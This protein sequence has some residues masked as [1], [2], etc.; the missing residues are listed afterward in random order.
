MDCMVMDPSTTPTGTILWV[1]EG[2]PPPGAPDGK[3]EASKNAN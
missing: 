3:H 1:G 2:W